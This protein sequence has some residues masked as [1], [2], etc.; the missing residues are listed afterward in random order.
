M[1]KKSGFTLLEVLLATIIV[2]VGVVAL[3]GAFSRG[4]FATADIENTD[5]AL[6]IAEANMEMLKNKNFTDINTTTKVSAL[7][8]NLS[9]SNFNVSGSVAEGQNP[10]QVNITVKWNVKG[11]QTNVTLTTLVANYS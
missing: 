2:T 7:L 1:P 5:R 10:M 3:V 8:T 6:K 9:F 4:L 11:G